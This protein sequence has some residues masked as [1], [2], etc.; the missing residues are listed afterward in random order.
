MELV[1]QQKFPQIAL[2]ITTQ[3]LNDGITFMS[4]ILSQCGWIKPKL[5]K[6]EDSIIR[7]FILEKL[8]NH[9]VIHF[10]YSFYYNNL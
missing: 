6:A 3:I 7:V 5:R 8:M 10:L 2:D 4:S 1:K 9:T